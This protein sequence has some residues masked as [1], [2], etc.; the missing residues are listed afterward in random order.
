MVIGRLVPPTTIGAD[1][2]EADIAEHR[3]N[4]EK[5]DEFAGITYKLVDEHKE[6]EIEREPRVVV[7]H[8]VVFAPSDLANFPLWL[9]DPG[10]SI[11]RSPDAQYR[12]NTDSLQW[13]KIGGPDRCNQFP[14]Y[15]RQPTLHQ[16]L[17]WAA[18]GHRATSL[19]WP[20]KKGYPAE[21]ARLIRGSRRGTG[22]N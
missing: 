22:R 7:D 1:Y 4:D 2:F 5:R 3:E 8:H 13:V 11:S 10:A 20:D 18:M 19:E 17:R 9:R 15:T 12:M 21:A 16:A 14:L 6:S